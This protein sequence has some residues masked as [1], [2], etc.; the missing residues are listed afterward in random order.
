MLVFDMQI[1]GM[2]GAETIARYNGTVPPAER[3]PII[4]ITADA[5]TEVERTCRQL[6]VQSLL[7]KPVSIERIREL[8]QRC[9]VMQ[10]RKCVAQ[11]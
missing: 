10:D 9:M 1:P 11:G 5:T 4:V 8:V 6:G 3:P 7:A 2:S